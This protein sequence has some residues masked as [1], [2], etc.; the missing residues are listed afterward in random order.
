M[1]RI[2]K[3]T[4]YGVVLLTNLA[5]EAGQA[6]RGAR[7]LAEEREVARIRKD[8]VTADHLRDKLQVLGWQVMDT[9]G[10]PQLK[11]KS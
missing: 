3:L 9:K 2:T 4:D 8:W 5:Q 11:R 10:G 1:F 7:D 6:P